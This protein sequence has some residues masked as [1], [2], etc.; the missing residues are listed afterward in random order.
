M[1]GGIGNLF[2]TL[3]PVFEGLAELGKA[4]M[5]TSL[6][7]TGGG[8]R[9]RLLPSCTCGASVFLV[10]E[11]LHPEIFLSISHCDRSW[12]NSRMPLV[13]RK[14]GFSPE[15]GYCFPISCHRVNLRA[16]SCISPIPCACRPS[17]P[18]LGPKLYLSLPPPGTW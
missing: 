2:S 17:L 10:T 7:D 5:L 18:S 15:D 12:R 14:A 16:L 4:E 11:C 8:G 13:R 6:E 1:A 9:G 3:T